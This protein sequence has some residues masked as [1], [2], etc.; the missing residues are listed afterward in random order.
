M[1]H[2]RYTLLVR[3]YRR[4]ACITP[5]NEISKTYVLVRVEPATAVVSGLP[6]LELTPGSYDYELGSF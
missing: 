4:H 1:F 5:W 2:A 6:F 3:T